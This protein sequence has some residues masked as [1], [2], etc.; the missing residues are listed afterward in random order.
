MLNDYPISNIQRVFK[1][2]QLNIGLAQKSNTSRNALKH[3]N[4]LNLICHLTDC[5]INNTDICFPKNAVYKV[6]GLHCQNF[7]I[8]ST[9]RPLHLRITEQGNLPAFTNT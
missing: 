8:G 6:P 3:R 7:Y 1:Q 9:I 2:E 5:P 4:E